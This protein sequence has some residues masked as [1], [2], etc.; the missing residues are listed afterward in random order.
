MSFSVLLIVL[1]AA[2]LHATW[3]F[4]LLAQSMSMFVILIRRSW[5]AI[6]PIE[7]PDR[8]RHVDFQIRFF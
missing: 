4:S 1:F 3:K 5:D 2:L 8:R 7:H 6:Q